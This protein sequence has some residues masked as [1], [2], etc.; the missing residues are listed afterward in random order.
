MDVI[1]QH[2]VRFSFWLGFSKM[3]S[4]MFSPKCLELHQSVAIQKCW[5]LTDYTMA[6]PISTCKLDVKNTPD[7]SKRVPDL[8]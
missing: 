3:C 5:D 6:L 7:A 2:M 8:F 4:P 1:K